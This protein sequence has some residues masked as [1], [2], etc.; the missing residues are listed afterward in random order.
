MAVLKAKNR[1]TC[2]IKLKVDGRWVRFPGVKDRSTSEKI[3]GRISKLI[4]AKTHHEHVQPDV[5]EWVREL[6]TRS[7]RLFKKLVDEGLADASLLGR[8]KLSDPLIGQIDEHDGFD[9]AV[10]SYNRNG[11]KRDHAR[12]KALVLRQDLYVCKNAGYLQALLADGDTA[13][14]VLQTVSRVDAVLTGCEFHHWEDLN[15]E[16]LK[17]WLHQ[18]RQTRADFGTKTSNHYIKAMRSFAAWSKRQLKRGDET[19]PFTDVELLNTSDDV[20]H[21]RRAATADEID[22]G[23]RNAI[24]GGADAGPSR[25]RVREPDSE[26][27]CRSR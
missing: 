10:Q 9:L 16:R 26:Q 27:F 5:L 24:S 11:N 6:P 2:D 17:Q 15:A 20:R 7:P 4:T 13:D 21:Q 25:Q 12:R 8:R 3:E 14:H 23:S 19:N 18:L 1:I 22:R